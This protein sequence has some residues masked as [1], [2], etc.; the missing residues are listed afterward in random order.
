MLEKQALLK[1]EEQERE[2]DL[3]IFRAESTE[4]TDG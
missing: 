2:M 4:G 1:R 3:L